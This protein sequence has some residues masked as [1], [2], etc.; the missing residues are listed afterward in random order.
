[1]GFLVFIYLLFI[2]LFIL[3]ALGLSCGMRTL[4]CRMH[5]GSSSPTRDRTRVPCIGSVESY[6][7]DHQ[8]SPLELALHITQ[9]VDFFLLHM[10][11]QSFHTSCWK[12]YPLSI[13]FCVCVF[14]LEISR[15]YRYGSISELFIPSLWSIF[16]PKSNCLDYWNSTVGFESRLC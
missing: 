4:S 3:A 1:M 8:G 12:D 7:L 13:E 10:N 16:I 9:D 11:I 14:L 5:E 2:Y 15:P 6:P